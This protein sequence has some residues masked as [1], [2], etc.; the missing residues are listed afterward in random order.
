M[1]RQ[2][3]CATTSRVPANSELQRRY[4]ATLDKQESDLEAIP[5]AGGREG[6]RMLV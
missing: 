1:N 6:R 4:L 5:S 2:P 3:A